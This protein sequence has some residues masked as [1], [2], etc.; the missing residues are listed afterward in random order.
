MVGT[1]A[2]CSVKDAMEKFIR[3]IIGF[4]SNSLIFAF[5]IHGVM[6]VKL[7]LAIGTLYAIASFIVDYEDFMS[8]LKNNVS[9]VEIKSHHGFIYFIVIVFNIVFWG[10]SITIR[11]INKLN[12][13]MDQKYE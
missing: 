3:D 5:V 13:L 10:Y 1:F 7:Y 12:R 11:A 9:E 6:P 4:L 2:E 8:S